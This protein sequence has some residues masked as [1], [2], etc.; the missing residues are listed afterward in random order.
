M[1]YFCHTVEHV[2]KTLRT[3]SVSPGITPRIW[4]DAIKTTGYLNAERFTVS[5]G[6]D[7][8]RA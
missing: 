1:Q 4:K 2:M 5:E 6:G 7:D 8:D 3:S